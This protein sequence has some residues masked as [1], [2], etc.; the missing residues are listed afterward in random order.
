M[1][2]G[3]QSQVLM[4][5]DDAHVLNAV[6][7]TLRHA[8]A[9][10]MTT[11]SSLEALD[12]VHRQDFAAIISDQRMPGIE[13]TRL[14]EEI[15]KV[16]PKPMRILLTA[17]PDLG[18]AMN[19]INR[20]KV[21]HFL[22]KPW[23]NEELVAIVN[24]AITVYEQDTPPQR[25]A[26]RKEA[27]RL[28]DTHSQ[29]DIE[30][31]SRESVHLLA[32]LFMQVRQGENID[33][34]PIFILLNKLISSNQCIDSLYNL[35]HSA[36]IPTESNLCEIMAVHAFKVGIFAL[37]IGQGL[38]YTDELMM[39]LGAAGFLHDIG[40]CLLPEEII[41]KETFTDADLAYLKKHPKLGNDVISQLGNSFQWLAQSVL[42]EHERA[43][44]S[45]YP[46]ALIGD[47][48]G[49]LAKIIGVVDT[50]TGLTASRPD[51]AGLIP[52]EAVKKI[53]QNYK[54]TFCPRILRAML[55]EL[56]AFPLQS[57]VR[58]NSGAIGRVIQTHTNSPC[59]PKLFILNNPN[60]IHFKDSYELD[61]KDNPILYIVDNISETPEP[62]G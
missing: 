37:K 56:S 29:A 10:V 47:E 39:D 6:Q 54:K 28:N 61:L 49:E 35:A 32:H 34:S 4:V 48:I 55:K 19:G 27:H 60:D 14:L 57:L 46:N 42:Q 50:Y 38:Q 22:T 43:D 41:K 11:Q 31:I 45:G 7:R 9:K 8:N 15:R 24:D 30:T 1:T 2:N 16:D 58:L 36:A 62:H 33:L 5:D 12:L 3:K 40:M 52:A 44:G 23:K 59:R 13:G 26:E 18:I 20:A 17:Y 21:S 51:R 53:T 25:L